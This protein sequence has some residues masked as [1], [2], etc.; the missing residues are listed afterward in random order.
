MG[1]DPRQFRQH[2]I[3]PALELLDLQG[4]AAAELLLATAAQE[5][6]MGRYI[7]QLGSG[8]ALGVFQM[9][10]ATYHDIWQNYLAYKPAISKRLAGRWPEQPPPE[11]MVTDLLLAAVMCRLHYRRVAKPLPAPG[12]IPAMAAYWKKYYNTPAGAGS[13]QE[14]IRNWQRHIQGESP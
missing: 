10:P 12:N 8:P 2:I 3:S 13:E 7:K 6:R 9:E 14:F 11:Q 5:S 1:I 4:V